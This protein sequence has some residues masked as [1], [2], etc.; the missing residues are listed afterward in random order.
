MISNLKTTDTAAFYA[1]LAKHNAR[2]SP[3]GEEW[4]L[5]N[6][7]NLENVIDRIYSLQ[8][9]A[10]FKFGRDK[11]IICSVLG[12]LITDSLQNLVETLQKQLDE[13]RKQLDEARN[14]IYLLQAALREEYLKNSNNVDLPQE[15]D[16]KET[17]YPHK[18]LA[19][20][21]N[22]GENCC[23]RM[24]RLIKTEYNYISDEDFDPHITTKQIPFTATKLAKLKKEFGRL[25][26]K[27]ETEY[28]FRVSLTGGD[29]IQLTEQEASG[30]WGH[31]VFLTTGDKRHTWSL[32]QRAAYWA[33]GLNPLE[34]GDPLAIIGS[35]D[36]L[37]ECVHKAACLQMIHERKL[38]RGYKSPM[39]LPVK[40]EMMTPLICGLPESLKPTAIVLQKTIAAMS[41]VERLDRFLRNP[42]DQTGST[43]PDNRKIWTWGEVAEDLINY[44]RKYGPIKTIEEKPEKIKGVRYIEAPYTKNEQHFSQRKFWWNLGIRKGIPR[45]IMDGLPLNQ[46]SRFVS[47]WPEG[48]PKSSNRRLNDYSHYRP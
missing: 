45:H 30:Y 24:R 8:H 47:S 15:T 28:V 41:P 40:S 33:G 16:T 43:D 6:W 19:L 1:L 4:A 5:D 26:H 18:E 9:A 38:M 23:P 36:Q 13:E 35:P 29:Q 48:K 11:T 2:P 37:L 17:I 25:P 31:G 44:N 22:Y 20:A 21:K 14:Q 27:S 42:T 10:K 7:F 32:T 46:L 12:A 34:R 39:Q 3:G